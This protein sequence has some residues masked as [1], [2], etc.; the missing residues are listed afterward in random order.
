[1]KL[2]QA[3][4]K[5][6][7]ELYVQGPNW[8][9]VVLCKDADDARLYMEEAVLLSMHGSKPLSKVRKDKRRIEFNGG[10]SIT[11]VTDEVHLMG[12]QY[13]HLMVA[14]E[15][16]QKLVDIGKM[17]LRHPNIDPEHYILDYV[18]I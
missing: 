7:R 18:E 17:W 15:V 5:F 13:P 12:V 2:A 8:R 1:M 3:L 11:F 9:A 10:G 4:K 16:P 14:P 6:R